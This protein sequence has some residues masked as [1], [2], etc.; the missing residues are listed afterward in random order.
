M[1]RQKFKGLAL[2]TLLFVFTADIPGFLHAWS[3]NFLDLFDEGNSKWDAKDF[4]YF[5]QLWMMNSEGEGQGDFNR[6]DLVDHH[7]LLVFILQYHL[8]HATATPVSIPTSS[9]PINQPTRSFTPGS[10]V[11]VPTANPS[12]T[13][14]PG[15]T[16]PWGMTLTP[17][18]T[19]THMS[20]R[21]TP[22]LTGTP[23]F[24]ET[25]NP[26][27]TYI[28][29]ETPN[30]STTPLDVPSQNPA[31]QTPNANETNISP[32]EETPSLITLTPWPASNEPDST[33]N[34]QNTQNPPGTANPDDNNSGTD[35]TPQPPVSTPAQEPD[36]DPP[37][38]VRQWNTHRYLNLFSEPV[39]LPEPSSIAASDLG[40]TVYTYSIQGELRFVS[41]DRFGRIYQRN[42]PMNTTDF[43]GLVFVDGGQAFGRFFESPAETRR[44]GYDQ[45]NLDETI[46]EAIQ[47]EHLGAD[48]IAW[49]YAGSESGA[50]MVI[51]KFPDVLSVHGVGPQGEFL[52]NLDVIAPAPLP[53]NPQVI[54]VVISGDVVGILY[55][56]DLNPVNQT[57]TPMYLWLLK[58][59]GTL[60]T[61]TPHTFSVPLVNE[62]FVGDGN[63]SLFFIGDS[64][65]GPRFHCIKEHGI[66]QERVL[67]V[68]SLADAEWQ[69]ERLWVLNDEDH[70]IYGFDDAGEMLAGPIG[71][72]PPG[73]PHSVQWLE[74][75]KSGPDLGAFFT[76]PSANDTVNYMQIEAGPMVTPTP[77]PGSGI[78]T[79]ATTAVELS[80]EEQI[81]FVLIPGGTYSGGTPEDE[82]G[83]FINEGPQHSVTITRDFYMS[84][85]EITNKQY[86]LFDPSH[87]GMPFGGI[88]LYG[89][90]LP[91]IRVTWYDAKD[92]CNWM[93]DETGLNITLPTEAEWEYAC[94]AGS[95][96]RR[97]WGDDLSNELACT[98]ANVADIQ[99]ASHFVYTNTFPCDDGY[100]GTAPVGSY[101]PNDFGMYDMMGNV[102]EWCED[103]FAPYT[104]NP[105][106]DPV[107][108]SRGY[109]KLIRGGS[110]QDSPERVRS[111]MRS[112]PPPD[113]AH[114]AVGFR[115]VLRE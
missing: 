30:P 78:P 97:Y 6:D 111:G 83:R 40:Y 113:R 25:V 69:D 88:D 57:I 87:D 103:W 70:S 104:T 29:S 43:S 105:V 93:S 52:G 65:F 23:A 99:A 27:Q 106:V 110:W 50:V 68:S 114:P 63:G 20:G 51:L 18:P 35:S 80:E 82:E 62:A 36:P 44:I 53:T 49:A 1:Y 60:I 45:F 33:P 4:Y 95:T 98:Y 19:P 66:M 100:A 102:W 79:G 67:A 108:P 37:P 84:K 61:E 16:P 59:D 109:S 55:S 38:P 2:L 22:V 86:R 5:S 56:S 42:L 17:T 46:A 34:Q 74:L 28:Y 90:D 72:Y 39:I 92:F 7:D 77:T 75:K 54:K 91:V 24:Q 58:L 64:T 3:Q 94:R 71:V 107:G 112:G 101:Q 26:T 15:I 31:H 89:D 48:A 76:D 85:Y 8:N 32:P 96:T 73:W 10:E 11:P 9:T 41:F 81:E 47:I 14:L 12:M 21:V 115:I 13:Y